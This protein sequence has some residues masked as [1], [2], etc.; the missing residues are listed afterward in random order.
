MFADNTEIVKKFAD[1][2][3][4]LVLRNIPDTLD[5]TPATGTER[6]IAALLQPH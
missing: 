4:P 2:I 6:S 1:T 5:S 3:S